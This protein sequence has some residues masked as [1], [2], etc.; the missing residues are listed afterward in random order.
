MTTLIPKFDLKNGG[1]TPTGA[2]NRPINE[3]LSEFISVKDFGAVGDG[4]TDDTTAIQTAINSCPGQTILVPFGTYK[5]TSTI[6]FPFNDY[7]TTTPAPVTLTGID[8]G[9]DLFSCATITGNINGPMFTMLG[10]SSSVST[11]GHGLQNL[12]INNTN[13]STTTSIGIQM[14]YIYYP[15]LKNLNVSA[16]A[17]CVDLGLL[18]MVGNFENIR[19]QNSQFGVKGQTC[20]GTT[21]RHCSAFFHKVCVQVIGSDFRITD[22]NAEQNNIVFNL[23]SSSVTIENSHIEVFD[24]L[25]TNDSNPI[26][27][28]TANYANAGTALNGQN[29]SQLSFIGGFYLAWNYA[30]PFMVERPNYDGSTADIFVNGIFV[31]QPT[32]GN[33]ITV[34]SAFNS[35]TPSVYGR[36]TFLHNYPTNAF[37]FYASSAG[38]I[39]G[40]FYSNQTQQVNST[41]GTLN[42]YISKLRVG[43]LTT[44]TAGEFY[45]SV[46]VVPANGTTS[47][48]RTVTGARRTDFVLYTHAANPGGLVFSAYVSANDTVTIVANNNTGSSITTGDGADL[49]TVIPGNYNGLFS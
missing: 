31:T 34:A 5:I 2:V 45:P 17:T 25:Q 49:I 4:T 9:R 47:W 43:A 8:D 13:T 36:Y 22:F 26:A 40:Y 19:T 21:W 14:G 27:Q 42:N 11:S 1:T 15:H 24:C 29:A 41:T 12:T 33:L 37:S 18:T 38:S 30:A 10:V 20:Y 39:Q 23:I 16:Y 46:Q 7:S 48:N 35:A 28:I 3:K 6:V 32:G 44:N